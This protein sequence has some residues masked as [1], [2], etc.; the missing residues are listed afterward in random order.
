MT[1]PSAANFPFSLEL[2]PQPA[3]LVGGAVRDALLNRKRREFDF[4]FV[5]ATQ[6]VETA[7]KIARICQ[8]GF[9]LL[10]EQRQIARVVFDEGTV[11]FALQEGD[12]LV[13]DLQRRDYTINA[14]AYNPLTTELIDPLEGQKDIQKGIL[15]MVSVANLEDDPLRLLRAYRFAAQLNFTIEPTTRATI[16]RLNQLLP[17]VAAE[18]V[19][20]ELNYLLAAPQSYIWLAAANEDKLLQFWFPQAT[21]E[22]FQLIEKVDKVTENV[23]EKFPKLAK[24]LNT[25]VSGKSLSRLNLAK[26]AC[27]VSTQ[28]AAAELELI[29]LKYSKAEIRTVTTALK[30]LPNLLPQS[31]REEYFLFQNLGDVFPTLAILALATGKEIEQIANLIKRYLNP[32]D[33]VAHPTSLV[34]GN[35]LINRL[36]LTPSPQIGKLL[37]E[38]QIARIEGKIVTVEDAIAFARELGT[39]FSD[40]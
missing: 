15:R 21:P 28:P 33:L 8:A 6:A 39:G 4:D 5:L 24:Q 23:V 2:L 7:S 14:I 34:T 36:K 25:S 35:D 29:Q 12:S 26:L 40:Q 37:T 19:Q 18:R 32:E 9:V 30:S 22:N 31:L 1:L 16:S 17:K 27:L 11:D 10:D 20:T 13:T 3:Y 38:I